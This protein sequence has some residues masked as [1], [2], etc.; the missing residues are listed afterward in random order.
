MN[1]Q[2]AQIW[3]RC[4][5][6]L[7]LTMGSAPVFQELVL[8]TEKLVAERTLEPIGVEVFR[9]NVPPQS[10]FARKASTVATAIPL[11]FNPPG[12]Y[13]AFLDMMPDRKFVS[14]A[15]AVSAQL[16]STKIKATLTNMRSF[17]V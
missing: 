6:T 3:E 13:M 7:P 16:P 11:A 15:D 2:T 9:L 14:E 12:S 10:V 17:R 1:A 4:V 5:E 8:A